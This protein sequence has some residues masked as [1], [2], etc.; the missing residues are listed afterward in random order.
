MLDLRLPLL[1]GI[2]T[3][4]G[5]VVPRRAGLPCDIWRALL[6]GTWRELPPLLLLT[7][8][9]SSGVGNWLILRSDN[10]PVHRAGS[11]LSSSSARLLKVNPLDFNRS[12]SRR[13][14][15]GR[16]PTPV[17]AGFAPCRAPV[18]KLRLRLSSVFS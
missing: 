5:V 18:V 12:G 11:E 13:L 1:L 17:R 16:L 3:T 14:A 8:E 2:P 10:G 4:R 9:V 6:F 15:R 7:D